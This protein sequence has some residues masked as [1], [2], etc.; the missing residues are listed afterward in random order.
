MKTARLL[1][2]FSISAIPLLISATAFAVTIDFNRITAPSQSPFPAYMESGFTVLPVAGS[3]FVNTGNLGNPTP[4]I[5]F[6]FSLPQPGVDTASVAVTHDSS[7]F[8]FSSIDLY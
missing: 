4:F 1:L 6:A 7:T 5:Y 3:W 2:K 8:S